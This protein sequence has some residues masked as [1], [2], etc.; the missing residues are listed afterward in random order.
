M[1]T[2]EQFLTD[3]AGCGE[4]VNTFFEQRLFELVGIL[5]KITDALNVEH[6]PQPRTYEPYS[7]R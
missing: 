3:A 4:V 5:H 1:H 2:F 6:I 7:G